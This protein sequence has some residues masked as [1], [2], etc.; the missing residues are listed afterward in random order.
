MSNDNVHP[1]FAAMLDSFK[2]VFAPTKSQDVRSMAELHL[3]KPIV[4]SHMFPP[5]PDRKHDW[6]AYPDGEEENGRYGW[7]PTEEA[8][9]ADLIEILRCDER[10]PE[11]F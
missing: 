8:A 10:I 6:C 2:A 11:S 3:G 9:V 7:G 5:I 4:T 1:I